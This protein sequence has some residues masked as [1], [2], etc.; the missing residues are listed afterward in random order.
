MVKETKNLKEQIEAEKKRKFDLKQELAK[1]HRSNKK[2][3][4]PTKIVE[5]ETQ[6]KI[7]AVEYFKSLSDNQKKDFMK[8]VELKEVANSFPLYLKYVYGD[9]YKMTKFHST[10]AMIGDKIVKGIEQG[11]RLMVC[12]SV[13]PQLGKSTTIT[14]SLPAYFLGRNPDEGVI[15]CSYNENYAEKFGNSNREKIRKYG[16]E[17][18]G[19]EVSPKMDTKT[20][21][22]INN[23]HGQMVSTGIFGEIT[24]NKASLLIIDDPFKSNIES[25]SKAYRDKVYEIVRQSCIPR[26]RPSGSAVV[27]IHTRW[28]EDDLIGRLINLDGVIYVNIPCV[29]DSSFGVDKLLGRKAG[30]TICPELNYTPKWVDETRKIMGNRSFNAL[31]QGKPYVDGG[32]IVQRN[33]IKIYESSQLPEKFDEVTLSADLTFGGMTKESDPNCI[34]VWGRKGADHYLLKAIKKKDKSNWQKGMIRHLCSLYPIERKIIERKANGQAIIDDL[35]MEFSGVLPFDPKG[36]SKETR[37]IA[38]TYFFEAG[39]IWF[40]SEKVMPD[41]EK[42]IEELIKFPAS[43]H[44]DFVDTLSQY[45]LNYKYRNGG[46][47]LTDSGYTDISNALRGL[48]I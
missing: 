19:I 11:K 17:L 3:K 14:E 15:I 35:C 26:L 46:K 42:Y 13:P 47:V 48:T 6:A 20:K 37:L 30:E 43:A 24:G 16:K 28:H 25:E 10:L 8:E 18:F 21:I 9:Y 12:I 1:V 39:N 22:E 40:P 44:D 41:V 45:L 5:K 38:V 31:Y 34:S 4:E 32:N 33:Q 23:R 2:E 27:V 29:W 7:D 36:D